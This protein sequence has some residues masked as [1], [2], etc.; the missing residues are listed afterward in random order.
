MEEIVDDGA[1]AIHFSADDLRDA[2]E[3]SELSLLAR[4]FWEEPRELRLVENA[5]IPVWQCGRVRI[6]DVG[7]GLY[8]FIFPS[9]SKRNWV[10]GRQPWVYQSFIINFTDN[11]VPSDD[12]FHSLQFMLIW[13]KI[14][15]MPF[16][17]RTT[18]LGRKLL[19]P[20]GQVEKMGYFDARTPEG[21][22]VKGKVRMDLY[23][24]FLGTTMA[25]CDDGITFPVFF[26]YEKVSCICY[27]CGYLGHFMSDCPFP[28]LVYDVL[29]RGKWMHLKVNPRE[30]EGQGPLLLR[31]NSDQANAGRGRGGLHPSVAAGL[32]STLQRQW[33]RGGRLG[34]ARRGGGPYPGGPRPLLALLGPTDASHHR[35]RQ[36]AVR[37]SGSGPTPRTIQ[38]LRSISPSFGAAGGSSRS[39]GPLLGG[40]GSI[41]TSPGS[42]SSSAPSSAR[43]GRQAGPTNQG[44]GDPSVDSEIRTGKRQALSS[45]RL[46]PSKFQSAPVAKADLCSSPVGH[47]TA[48]PDFEPPARPVIPLSGPTV[49]LGLTPTSSSKRKLLEDFERDVG[50]PSQFPSLQ[51]DPTKVADCSHVPLLDSNEVEPTNLVDEEADPNVVFQPSTSAA[52]FDP[53]ALFVSGSEEGGSLISE[54]DNTNQEA[55]VASLDRLP[56]DQ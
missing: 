14:T 31:P 47:H 50:C 10:L 55:E 17:Y 54:H 28:G 2:R 53:D 26:S 23:E 7:F 33:A 41:Q 29:V 1:P 11:M 24:P 44:R 20:M 12:V 37:P 13:V 56:I 22:Y 45:D 52:Q 43:L 42:A 8:Q 34:G 6:F 18:A 38:P 51:L 5:F 21:F 49:K 15:G 3:R 32:S 39:P 19:A 16:A 27:L 35:P 30:E 40:G 9:V 46:E 36:G 48:P 25:T 4:I